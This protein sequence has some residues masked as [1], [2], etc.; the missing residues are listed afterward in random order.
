[1]PRLT[2]KKASSKK[3]PTPRA[4]AHKLRSVQEVLDGESAVAIAKRYGDSPRIVS[5]WVT[6]YQASGKGGLET[7]PRS[8]RPTKLTPQQ[9]KKVERFVRDALRRGERPTGSALSSFVSRSF[10]VSMTVQHCRRII[11]RMT[12]SGS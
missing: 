7:K 4:L 12:A 10:A 11:S 5:Y 1:M 6:Q 3:T 9:Q 8:G 2:K